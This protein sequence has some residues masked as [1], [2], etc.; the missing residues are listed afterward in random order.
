[1]L[2]VKL[3]AAIEGYYRRTGERMTYERLSG[4][5]GL[6]RATLASLAS[7]EGYDTRIS[8]IG[9]LCAALG[10]TPG[11]LLELQDSDGMPPCH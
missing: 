3:R 7:R 6:S 8:T 2:R 1:M 4:L 10:C 11:E 9:K 5:T